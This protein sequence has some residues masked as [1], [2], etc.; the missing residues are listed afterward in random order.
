MTLSMRLW[1]TVALLLGSSALLHALSHGEQIIPREPLSELPYSVGVWKGKDLPLSP[2][3]VAALN[4]TDHANR[5]YLDPSSVPV[6][7]YIGYYASQRTGDTIHSPKNCLPGSG[8]EPIRSGH[9]S[10]EVQGGRE[11]TVNEYVIQKEQDR[12]MVFYWY[13]DGGRVI[14]SEYAAKFWMV[15]DAILRNRTDGALVR[16]VTPSSDG[17][18][19]ARSRLIRFTQVLFP[20]LNDILPN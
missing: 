2:A 3:I 15:S 12:E 19:N 14:A 18:A 6:Q 7:L 20:R 5:D 13:Q 1:M 11:I 10:I 17:E 4:V 8:W 16:V 9:L